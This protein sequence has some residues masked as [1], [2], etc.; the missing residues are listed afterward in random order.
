[1]STVEQQT[2]LLS[3]KLNRPTV[4]GDL[5][6]RNR[7]HDRMDA[8][9]ECP[10][11]LVSAPAGYGKS[12]LAS[13]WA[14]SLEIPLGWVS[15][16]ESDADLFGFLR[17]FVA[18]VETVFPDTCPETRGLLQAP[19]P[20]P[21]TGL[22]NSLIN[23]LDRIDNPFVLVLDD[24]HL[25]VPSSEVHELLRLLLEHPPEP[26]HLVLVTRRDPPLPIASMRASRRVVE[27]RLQDLQFTLAETAEFLSTTTESK[28]SDE[29]MNNLQRQTE[30][31]AAGLCLVTQYLSHCDD[32][33]QFLKS[34]AGGIQLTEQYL[35]QE[36]L[37]RRSPQMQE[38]LLRSS[39][40]DRFSAALC[41][42]VCTPGTH[43]PEDLDGRQ[44]IEALVRVNLFTISLDSQGEWYRYHHLFQQSLHEELKRRFGSDE[45]AAMHLRASE[46]FESQ[47]LITDAIEHAIKGD[48]IER[49]A[50][51]IERYRDGEQKAER[52]HT[53]ESWLA[54]LPAEIRHKRPELA[55]AEAAIAQFRFRLD[56]IPPLLE[57]AEQLLEDSADPS[58]LG[59]LDSFHGLFQ[60]W[61]GDSRGSIRLLERALSQLPDSHAHVV[62]N[63]E[64][65]LALARHMEG[66]TE[67]A[68]DRVNERIHAADPS[69]ELFLSYL[70]GAIVY[71]R[72]LAGEL[73]EAK[74]QTVRMQGVAS[75]RVPNCYAWVLYFQ[76]YIEFHSHNPDRALELFA[77]A[78]HQRYFM[79]TPAVIDSLAG[80]AITEQLLGRSAAAM[81]T[82]DRLRAATQELNTPDFLAIADSCQARLSLLQGDVER[83]VDWAQS[84]HAAPT[85]AQLFL[86]ME[87]PSITKARVLIAAGTERS[88]DEASELLADIRTL[89]RANHFTNAVIEVAVLQALAWKKRGHA[90]EALEALEEAVEL[91]RP[92]GWVRPFVEAG[93][94]MAEMLE[95]LDEQEERA[96]FVK[97]VLTA[98][99]VS[100]APAPP[101]DRLEEPTPAEGAAPSRAPSPKALDD[102]TDRELDVLEL[103]AQRL[104]NKEIAAQ[105]CISTHTVNY[106][107]KHIYDKLGV[108]SR[109][110]AVEQALER[111]ILDRA[112]LW[113]RRP[114]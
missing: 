26:L 15:L 33:E 29:A 9:L 43:G 21:L 88:L 34:L 28:V 104:Q 83:A 87:V 112:Q 81:E 8:S 67:L 35:T 63:T 39:I 7:L 16:D 59:E 107:L 58:L 80:Q 98:F 51:I 97:R 102:L 22:A 27:I 12:M 23:E 78:A 64:L 66:Q 48:D 69:E 92:G 2:A 18:A 36:V 103:L 79:D 108:Q 62:S 105:L 40:L 74:V 72:L 46:W 24:Y 95:R 11:T 76:A 73:R 85:V 10:L 30:G 113:G 44:F 61:Q 25:L 52:W 37:G 77:Q 75:E 84:V 96:G 45:M 106:H 49:A 1:M 57:Q 99:A 110:Q 101:P 55:L 6:C 91:A 70:V 89:S 90:D 60:F 94:T 93:P 4:V 14:E 20:P 56:R 47:G 54:K 5:V 38:W 114:V 100:G 65:M 109:R 111:G 82:C 17:Y 86:W 32:P 41:E 31:W 42:A 53:V 71:M 50:S 68:I 13:H 19:H 3:T